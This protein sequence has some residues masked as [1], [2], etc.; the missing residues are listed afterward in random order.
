MSGVSSR[1][2]RAALF[3][4][5]TALSRWSRERSLKIDCSTQ[6]CWLS[7]GYIH[8]AVEI[9]IKQS[10]SRNSALHRGMFALL[11]NDFNPHRRTAVIGHL[12]LLQRYAIDVAAL[13]ETKVHGEVQL[14]EDGS[15]YSFF[16]VGGRADGP[17]QA[18]VGFA[19]RF[20]LFHRVHSRP[21]GHCSRIC[22]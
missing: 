14:E 17:F 1:T 18:G 2:V 22:R 4:D 3:R 19:I 9:H 11:D 6:S 12:L 8:L 16:L 13:S 21:T 20:T 10:T 15:G 5:G 7:A